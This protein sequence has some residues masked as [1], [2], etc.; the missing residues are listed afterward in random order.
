ME[1]HQHVS[2]GTSHELNMCCM[3]KVTRGEPSQCHSNRLCCAACPPPPRLLHLLHDLFCKIWRRHEKKRGNKSLQPIVEGGGWG[4][5]GATTLCQPSITA[6]SGGSR[7]QMY[8]VLWT[9]RLMTREKPL[10]F[11]PIAGDFTLVRPVF[12]LFELVIVC[13]AGS[14]PKG[15]FCR[16][17]YVSTEHAASKTEIS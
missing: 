14:E 13:L 15:S 1:K 8:F 2:T 4:G 12:F 7:T 10:T 6:A 17:P 9:G 16:T 5:G 11:F 3:R